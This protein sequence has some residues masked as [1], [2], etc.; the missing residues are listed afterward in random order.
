[1]SVNLGQL[2]DRLGLTQF[3]GANS[4]RAPG[5]N[6]YP[7]PGARGTTP[8]VIPEHF[9]LAGKSTNKKTVLP[10]DSHLGQITDKWSTGDKWFERIFVLPSEIS[11]GNILS[12][13]ERDIEVYSSHRSESVTLNVVTNNLGTGTTLTGVP[14]L[15]FAIGP[16]SGFVATLEVSTLGAP[17]LSDAIDF[18]FASETL[19]VTVVGQRIVIFPFKPLAPMRERL[20]FLTDVFLHIDGSE[21][22]VANRLHPRQEFE[23]QLSVD[24]S[25]RRYLENLI[26]DWHSSVFGVPVWT[27]PAFITALA[28]VGQETVNVDRTDVS[29]FREGGLAIVFV[30]R[31]HYDALEVVSVQP[32]SI[33]FGSPLTN[34]Y[35]AG[36]TVFPLRECV[37][38]SNVRGRRAVVNN[39]ELS[40]GFRCTDNDVGVN[41]ASVS[42]FSS[43]DGK[44]L[45]DGPNSVDRAMSV[46]LE[47]RLEEFDNLTGSFGVVSNWGVSR[48]SSVKGFTTHDRQELWN[49]RRLLHALRG[50][51]ISFWLPT[52]QDELIPTQTLQQG[53]SSLNFENV[54]FTKF[55][56]SRAPS[57]GALRINLNDGTQLVRGIVSSSEINQETESIGL[58]D[59]WPSTYTVGEVRRIDYL[60]LVRADTDN[61]D[62][63]HKDANGNATIRF[64]VKAVIE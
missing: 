55:A 2:E 21:Q 5:W 25:D 29:D 10:E 54:G 52:F 3:L 42:A 44:V 7:P 43:Y 30:D 60:E 4:F 58:D 51:Q 19:S 6:S 46:V 38:K 33:T 34:A 53:S 15:P 62:I 17:A 26:Y 37:A 22:R 24:G 28:Q 31:H 64:P 16:A 48:R 13:L 9:G 8:A 39:T 61:I 1:M 49:V 35:Q 47:R 14:T 23:F 50:K 45:L 57:R 20:S 41:L 18:E 59:T 32:S 11:L 40:V 36:S 56:Q 12:P 63:Q 27:E